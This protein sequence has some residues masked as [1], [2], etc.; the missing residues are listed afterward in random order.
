MKSKWDVTKDFINK[1][2]TNFV[3]TKKEMRQI[4]GVRITGTIG[5]Y[6]SYLRNEGYVNRIGDATYQKLRNIPNDLSTTKL[7]K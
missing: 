2:D 6:I 1:L 7:M 3:F 4:T 5:A